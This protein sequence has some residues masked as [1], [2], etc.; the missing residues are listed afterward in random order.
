MGLFSLSATRQTP[1]KK[2]LRE[3]YKGSSVFKK[4]DIIMLDSRNIKTSRSNKSLNYKNLEPFK[5]VRTI[6]NM[7]YELKLLDDINI[8]SVFYL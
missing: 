6:N 2:F 3:G 4:E 8:F 5:I 1:T 7:T